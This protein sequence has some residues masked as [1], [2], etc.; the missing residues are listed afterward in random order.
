[1]IT[2]KSLIRGDCSSFQFFYPSPIIQ[3]IS[4]RS[5]PFLWKIFPII[6]APLN[7]PPP[8]LVHHLSHHLSICPIKL[9]IQLFLS[10]DLLGN[11]VQRSTP[12]KY[13][14]KS[15]YNAFNVVVAAFPQI[16]WS[17][18]SSS[19]ASLCGGN[20]VEN[21]YNGP[22]KQLNRIQQIR[23]EISP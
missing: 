6:Q 19:E 14:H 13:G 8:I 17:L 12:H 4:L 3:K 16:F 21:H 11:T 9:L 7:H 23:G 22:S 2:D 1:M 5:I 20:F 18:P 10:D 15:R